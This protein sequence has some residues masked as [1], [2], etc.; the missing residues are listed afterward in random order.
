LGNTGSWNTRPLEKPVLRKRAPGNNG[1]WKT[2]A[3]GKQALVKAVRENTRT[4]WETPRAPEKNQGSVKQERAVETTGL[5]NTGCVEKADLAKRGS[6]T[7]AAKNGSQE[8]ALKTGLVNGR[9]TRRSQKGVKESVENRGVTKDCDCPVSSSPSPLQ[10][11]NDSRKTL[12]R[13]TIKQ[14]A[15]NMK[16]ARKRNARSHQGRK[17]DSLD[18]IAKVRKRKMTTED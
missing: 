11:G 17:D 5:E 18:K 15:E 4:T 10:R 2:R 16:V 13:C 14:L 9:D 12:Q 8:R 3:L 6:N 1:A 7:R